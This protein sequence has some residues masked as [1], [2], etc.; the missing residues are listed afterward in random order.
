MVG[1]RITLADIVVACALV[2][3]YQSVFGA[4]F[5]EK[6]MNVNRWFSTCINQPNFAKVLG[7]VVPGND[8]E[9]KKPAPSKEQPSKK[10]KEQQ[11]KKGKER[12]SK[13]Q[14]ASHSP[15]EA[16]NDSADE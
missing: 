3:P 15:P 7:K 6:F 9:E 11:S 1:H 8:S 2:D 10:E 13:K 5:G 4:D 14:Q 16:S 12:Q